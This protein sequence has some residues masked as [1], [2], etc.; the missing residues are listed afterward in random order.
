MAEQRGAVA[1][2][3]AHVVTVRRLAV[4]RGAMEGSGGRPGKKAP[5]LALSK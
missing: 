2:V 5:P 3:T 1:M 4:A